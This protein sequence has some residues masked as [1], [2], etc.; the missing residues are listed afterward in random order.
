MFARIAVSALIAGFAAGLF[1]ALLQFLFV[2]PI[3][4]HAE[5]F[6]SGALTHFGA[7]E[8][9][10]NVPHPFGADLLR[11]G[12]SV[13][14]SAL[15]Y[16]G[17]AL[18][19]LAVMAFA[20]ERGTPISARAGLIWG[21]AGFVTMGLAPAFGLPPELPGMAAADITTRQ[22]WWFGTVAA[23]GLGLWLVAFG[24]SWAAWGAAIILLA[25]P[26][27]IG[28]PVPDVLTGPA[29]PELGAEFAAR[30]LGNGLAVWAVLGLLLG[31]VWTS[32]LSEV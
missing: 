10:A 2:Q 21:V 8:S 13:M 27:L 3:L 6:E 16:T 7:T 14:F 26:H 17:Y 29:P 15:T 11:N 12:M 18:L 30:V 22:V 23:T 9:A 20:E 19:L 32:K 28:A 25:A 24:A 31:A 1:A 5:L 4:L